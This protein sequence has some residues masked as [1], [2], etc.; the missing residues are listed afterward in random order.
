LPPNNEIACWGFPREGSWALTAGVDSFAQGKT[1]GCPAGWAAHRVQRCMAVVNDIEGSVARF[2]GNA[3][4]EDIALAATRAFG[5]GTALV[6]METS[7][8]TVIQGRSP[9]RGGKWK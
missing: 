5:M 3:G 8:L 9:Y 4:N 2:G 7:E 6:P 1:V